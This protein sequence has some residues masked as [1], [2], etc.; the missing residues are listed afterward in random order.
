MGM[1]KR[2]GLLGAAGAIAVVSA[3]LLFG[4]GNVGTARSCYADPTTEAGS[5]VNKVD[6]FG[7][8][9]VM[10]GKICLEKFDKVESYKIEDRTNLG[11]VVDISFE[12]GADEIC[13]DG[14]LKVVTWSR[15][16]DVP[17]YLEADGN[18]EFTLSISCTKGSSH[19]GY[20]CRMKVVSV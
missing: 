9:E 18:V 20:D 13:K 7:H 3:I 8:A 6:K 14:P 5:F 1:D 11:K 17:D 15:G 10:P 16:V 4:G 12:C 2:V 19:S